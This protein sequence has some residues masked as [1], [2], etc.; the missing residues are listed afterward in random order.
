MLIWV[1]RVR[2]PGSERSI[3]YPHGAYG[4][5][6]Q[7]QLDDVETET[8]SHSAPNR[9]RSARPALQPTRTQC[10]PGTTHPLRPAVRLP[11]AQTPLP[12]AFEIRLAGNRVVFDGNATVW[13]AIVIAVMV[14]WELYFV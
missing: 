14:H 8:R 11:L 13:A 7:G 3:D 5:T 4:A 12:S 10:H 2:L 6:P 9:P 1:D